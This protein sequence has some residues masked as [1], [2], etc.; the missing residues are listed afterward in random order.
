[1][2]ENSAPAERLAA[3]RARRAQ[4]TAAATRLQ[5]LSVGLTGLALS[6]SKS[7]KLKLLK[8]AKAYVGRIK[9]DSGS[10]LAKTL[11]TVNNELVSLE[12]GIRTDE[13]DTDSLSPVTTIAAVQSTQSKIAKL[14]V[15][16]AQLEAGASAHSDQNERI[17]EK[18]REFMG[19]LPTLTGTD[20]EFAIAR[21]PVAFTFQ[22]KGK[23]SSVGYVDVQALDLMGFKADNVG[24]Y[25]ILQNQLMIG[26]SVKAIV[27]PTFDKETGKMILDQAGRPV[28][29]PR[30][31][32]EHAVKFKGGKPVKVKVKRPKTLKDVAMMVLKDLNLKTKQNYELVQPT[33]AGAKGAGWFWVMPAADIKRL[34]KAM[35][36][37]HVGIAKWGFAS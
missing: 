4:L 7:H 13:V 26:I 30:M 18:N 2:I 6:N 21:M 3:A 12:D 25:T 23:H 31:I 16:I 17:I 14:D 32:S 29:E 19:K 36:G 33:P 20:K 27:N 34:A 9:E 22:N 5:K 24:G 10:L 28:T 8:S 35:P 15:L 37:N 1:M 11:A